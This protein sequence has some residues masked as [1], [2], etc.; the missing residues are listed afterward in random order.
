LEASATT[1]GEKRPNATAFLFL[2][3]FSTMTG[4]TVLFAVLASLFRTL[5]LG[6]FRAGLLVTVSALVAGLATSLW[7]QIS[8]DWGR[9]PVLLVGMVGGAASLLLF[10]LVAHLGFDRALSG[11]PLYALVL[12][13]RGLIFGAFFIAVLVAAQ[14]YVADT[15]AGE[16][17]RTRGISAIQAG[18]GLGVVA[19]PGFGGLLAG[20]GLLAP[21][22]AA[23]LFTLLVAVVVWRLL[24]AP[25]ARPRRE[26]S[27]GPGPRD[28]RLWPFLLVGFVVWL[29]LGAASVTVSFLFGDRLNIDARQTA[30]LAGLGLS[31]TGL[32]LAFTQA[33]LVARL[34]WSPARLI[35]AGVAVAAVAFLALAF[36]GNAVVLF[37]ALAVLG[38]GLGLAVP[39]FTAGPTL[40]A[41]DHEQGRVSGLV[42]ATSPL[43][44][45]VAPVLWTGLYTAG[46]AYPYGAAAALL[47]LLLAFTLV[48]PLLRR[49]TSAPGGAGTA[50]DP[51]SRRGGTA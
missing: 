28:A 34:G 31:T 27:R 16:R 17:Q 13:T 21:L 36:A 46:T 24:P 42:N 50:G 38:V 1:G 5:E 43:S 26:E 48:H 15:T 37:A 19:G 25:R 51:A 10:A 12:L 22:Y 32:T 11:G 41:A 49:A 47:A 7:G 20:F 35:R 4:Q 8:D 45:V 33:A 2:A 3:V 18:N 39:G 6:A 14:A 9:K 30:T 23:P 29:C 44:F 40:L